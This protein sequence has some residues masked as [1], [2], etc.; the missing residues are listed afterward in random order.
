MDEHLIQ[1]VPVD[2]DD[3]VILVTQDF[4]YSLAKI[5]KVDEVYVSNYFSRENS[6]V[7]ELMMCMYSDNYYR[8][9]SY[10]LE[11]LAEKDDSKVIRCIKIERKF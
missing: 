5:F 10:Y 4:E 9:G 2:L 11:V 3:K 8:V 7:V 1:Q 6:Y